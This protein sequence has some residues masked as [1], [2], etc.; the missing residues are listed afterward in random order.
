MDKYTFDKPDGWSE[1]KWEDLCS[2]L[3]NALDNFVANYEEDEEEHLDHFYALNNDGE[4]VCFV[5]GK[6]NQDKFDDDF[7]DDE[8]E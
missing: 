6:S 5:C 4:G 7:E 3:D 2:A 8:D 1:D